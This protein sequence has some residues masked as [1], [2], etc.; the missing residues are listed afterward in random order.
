[1]AT[2]I[3]TPVKHKGI[4]GQFAVT[5][6]VTYDDESPVKY[7]FVGSTYGGPVVMVSPNGMQVFVAD[8]GR[9]GAFG[10]EWVRRFF[11]EAAAVV[12]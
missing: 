3:T 4:A 6:T 8:P 12:V 7:E 11:E 5:T 1:M 9:F 2:T 10:V